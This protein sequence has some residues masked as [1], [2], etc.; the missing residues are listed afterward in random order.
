MWYT[1]NISNLKNTEAYKA[2]VKYSDSNNIKLVKIQESQYFYPKYYTTG[3]L[4]GDTPQVGTGITS[5][6]YAI[7]T[8]DIEKSIIK[9]SKEIIPYELLNFYIVVNNKNILIYSKGQKTLSGRWIDSLHFQFDYKIPVGT[10]I[11]S[12]R[13]NLGGEVDHSVFYT[14]CKGI[15]STPIPVEWTKPLVTVDISQL[16]DIKT[17]DGS[18]GVYTIQASAL[19]A[20]SDNP[21][22]IWCP[23]DKL[24]LTDKI[25][26]S[27]LIDSNF[28]NEKI[29]K[30]KELSEQYYKDLNK[31]L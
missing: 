8:I 12:I 13:G 21:N 15:V 23:L 2:L 11:T 7:T 20:W 9:F 6:A 30:I 16:F 28:Q 5:P 25:E 27:I 18:I 29:F 24:L 31:L 22:I 17:Y 19:T 14:Y 26:D 3:I 1:N 10:V 4:V